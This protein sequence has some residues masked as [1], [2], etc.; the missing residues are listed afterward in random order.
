M[1]VKFIII[2]ALILTISACDDKP[3]QVHDVPD[4]PVP[5]TK[6]DQFYYAQ[7]QWGKPS[8][9]D[10]ITMEVPDDTIGTETEPYE[11]NYD[12][13]YMVK[14][15]ELRNEPMYDTAGAKHWDPDDEIQPEKYGW[16]Y[17]PAAEFITRKWFELKLSGDIS[18]EDYEAYYGNFLTIAF[19][20]RIKG[21]TLGFWDIQDYLDHPMMKTGYLQWGRVGNNVFSDSIWNMDAYTGVVITYIDENGEEWSTDNPPTFQDGSYFYVKRLSFNN[22]DNT[23]YYLMEGEFK[24]KLY[25]SYGE[26]KEARGGKFRIPIM[27]QI[28]LSDKPH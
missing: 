19:P 14:A 12:Y 16:H 17:V 13:D 18:P 6:I 23:T 3:P 1:K 5:P 20:W 15:K 21:D 22:H 27:T 11:W 26:Y 25:N 9:K 10:T 4:P 8:L 7:F 2:Y 28:E 24:A